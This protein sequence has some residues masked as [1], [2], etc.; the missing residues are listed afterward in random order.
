MANLNIEL[1]G[2]KGLQSL[3]SL[4]S[5]SPISQIQLESIEQLSV[6][7]LVPSEYQPRKIWDEDA[8]SELAASISSQGIIQPL[9]VRPKE[10]NKFEI[11]AGE[12]RWRA[13][14]EAGLTFVPAV[15][16]DVEDNI[17]LAFALIENIQRE[18]LGS[19]E[20]ASAFYRFQNDFSMTHS[21]IAKMVGRSRASVTNTI[22]LLSLS[23]AVKR[24]LEDKSLSMGHARALLSLE[25]N[26]QLELAQRIVDQKLT[27]REIEGLV[28]QEKSP[29]VSTNSKKS[30]TYGARQDF[31]ETELS[32]KFSSK[33]TVKLNDNGV[34]RIII[35]VDN[36]SEIDWLINNINIL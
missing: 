14:I 16:R 6:D 18:D 35:H 30:N 2:L 10:N 3:D 12:R 1:K 26:E 21:D 7:S 25:E 4:L 36:P 22:R 17:A 8:L 11:I 33:V 20:E 27:V 23:D 28:H 32:K 34:G 15:I 31:W 5:E 19:L 13:A 29:K 9:I 24:L